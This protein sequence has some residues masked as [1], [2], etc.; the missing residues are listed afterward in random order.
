MSVPAPIALSFDRGTLLLTGLPQ[1]RLA[2]LFADDGWAWDPR[3][4]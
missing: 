4:I 3:V 2:L 1:R